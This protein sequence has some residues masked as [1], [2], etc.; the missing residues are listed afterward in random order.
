ARAHLDELAQWPRQT[1]FLA[2]GQMTLAALVFGALCL[3]FG[4]GK[5]LFGK[6][7][8]TSFAMACGGLGVCLVLLM[9]RPQGDRADLRE[10]AAAKHAPHRR[11]EKRPQAEPQALPAMPHPAADVW[12][13]M[14]NQVAQG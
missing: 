14:P 2:L 13:F 8:T 4:L 5:L 7:A 11:A 10:A 1:F 6:P 3:A 12:R 9:L